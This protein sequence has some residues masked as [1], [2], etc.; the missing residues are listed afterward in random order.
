M[1]G[2]LI[3][4]SLLPHEVLTRYTTKAGFTHYSE[5]LASHGITYIIFMAEKATNAISHCFLIIKIQTRTRSGLLGKTPT[6]TIRLPYFR[7]KIDEV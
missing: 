4:F 6:S 2:S 5:F 7:P 1:R 3:K